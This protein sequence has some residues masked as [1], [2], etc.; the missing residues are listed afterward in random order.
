MDFLRLFDILPYQAKRF[1][2]KICL[3]EKTSEGSDWRFFSTLE[4]I[5]TAQKWSL[6]LL[7][8]GV[9]KGQRVGI[10]AHSGSPEWNLADLALLQ[11]GAV[12]VPI[13]ATAR[14]D[15]VAFIF[16]DSSLEACF[17]SNQKMLEKLET[18]GV[19]HSKIWTF[20]KI[21]G[22]ESVEKL[23]L[24]PTENRRADLEKI[25]NSISENDLATLIYTS[26]TTGEPKGVMLTHKNIV[27]NIKAVLAIAPIHD[28]ATAVSFLPLSHVFERMVTFAYMA[29]GTSIYYLD[30]QGVM[31]DDL[32]SARPSFFTAVP[33][34]LE[35][36]R[37]EILLRRE[38]MGPLKR[39]ILDW[40]IWVG[41]HY[42][43]RGWEAMRLEY[44][45]RLFFARLL[46]F[47]H[48]K[49]ALG[50][51]VEGVCVGAAALDP[52]L[53]RLFSAAQIP[54]REGY[55]L[56]ET[57]PVVA[58]NRFEP[59]GNHFGTVGMAAPGVEIRIFEP[60]ANEIGEIQVKGPNVMQG[61]FQRES[62]TKE[63]FTDD[64]WLRTGDM[65]HLVFKRFLKITGRRRELFKTSSGK[66]I[67]P[68]FVENQLVSSP[69]VAQAM[70]TGLGRSWPAALIVPDFEMLKNWCAE[71]R[72]HWTSPQ[73]MAINPKVEKLFA[74]LVERANESL[75]AP[76]KVRSFR[77][78]FENWSAETG[79]MTATLKL[80]R[81]FLEEKFRKE[82][83]E[84]YAAGPLL[85]KNDA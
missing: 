79:E 54:I 30:N 27:S 52:R 8:N 46:V 20:E 47:R 12:P 11:I 43:S 24:E 41:E 28:Q 85:A 78:L 9:Q 40:A 83:E 39:R 55:G 57:S 66:F 45:V 80:R 49:K 48:W 19:V 67:A 25:K 14:P 17:V 1:P 2:K 60:D 21:D 84:M 36:V 31:L 74:S 29:A 76:E 50:G 23:A 16:R 63:M 15:E 33:R 18:A 35:K 53:A 75:S 58:F 34:F 4:A 44:R 3:A 38:K 62:E 37:H 68:Q 13:H 61:Y 59:G 64:G 10:L 51:R 82:I 77:L 70:V 32:R 73:F 56:T 71:N 22:L 6:G 81:P 7:E 65:G 72:V 26:G 5:Q 42:P 69:F